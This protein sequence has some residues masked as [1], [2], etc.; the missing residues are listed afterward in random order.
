MIRQKTIVLGISGG[1]AA[2]KAPEL[3]RL[4]QQKGFTVEC[5]LTRSA[6]NFVKLPGVKVYLDL[7]EPDF[8]A[9]K[10]L[11][12]SDLAKVSK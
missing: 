6:I 5:V 2:V 3:V 1:I 12:F 8:D 9:K 10:V 11:A 7:F 4:L